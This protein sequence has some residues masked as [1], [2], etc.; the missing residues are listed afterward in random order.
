MPKYEWSIHED[1]TYQDVR[2]KI[3]TSK[4]KSAKPLGGSFLLYKFDKL[5]KFKS[6]GARF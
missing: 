4:K 6:W 1:Q 2:N 3:L 5:D